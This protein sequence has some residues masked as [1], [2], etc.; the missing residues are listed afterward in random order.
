VVYD[1]QWIKMH[2]ETIKILNM[3]FCWVIW[4]QCL[5]P[6]LTR[7]QMFS[8]TTIVGPPV[9]YVY[10]VSI[11]TFVSLAVVNRSCSSFHPRRK[12]RQSV[13]QWWNVKAECNLPPKQKISCCKFRKTRQTCD[14]SASD[15][16]P[17]W[18]FSI[19]EV[20][21]WNAKILIRRLHHARMAYYED[22]RL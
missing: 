15:S 12:S 16:Q 8:G 6:I 18:K 9:S 7:L 22:S 4:I 14:R 5:W 10:S 17:T 11:H 20:P 13:G 21:N 2:G 1:I 3:P 19:Q